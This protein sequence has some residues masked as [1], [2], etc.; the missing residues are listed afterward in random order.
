MK[1]KYKNSNLKYINKIVKKLISIKFYVRRFSK[2]IIF[3][4]LTNVLTRSKF[5]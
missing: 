1:S 5:N 4:E 2:S 3:N